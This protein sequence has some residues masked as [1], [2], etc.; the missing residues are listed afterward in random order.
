METKHAI[1]I[2]TD[3]HK[4]VRFRVR[5]TAGEVVAHSAGYSNEKDCLQGIKD[6][7]EVMTAH[8]LSQ[9]KIAHI[10]GIEKSMKK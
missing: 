5:N 1:E 7:D 10:P 3:D 9:I 4:Q 6:L 2:F 8:R